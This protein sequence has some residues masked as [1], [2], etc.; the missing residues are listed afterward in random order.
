MTTSQRPEEFACSS[1]NGWLKFVLNPEDTKVSLQHTILTSVHTNK[2]LQRSANLASQ[3][4]SAKTLWGLRTHV[5]WPMH[6]RGLAAGTK[7]H[8]TLCTRRLG[9]SCNHRLPLHNLG[10][11]IA[12][13]LWHMPMVHPGNHGL[14]HVLDRRSP[15][16]SLTQNTE[17]PTCP[18]LP[19]LQF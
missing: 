18:C 16:T 10:E 12:I 4:K 14:T 15:H 11:C 17:T 6:R 1:W 19:E 13:R 2:L 8:T 9:M 7:L 5:C 3:A